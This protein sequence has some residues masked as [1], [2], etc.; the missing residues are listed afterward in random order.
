LLN[1]EGDEIE[2]KTLPVRE[3]G[4]F[5]GADGDTVYNGTG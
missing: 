5:H 1:G 3:V 4:R 2:S